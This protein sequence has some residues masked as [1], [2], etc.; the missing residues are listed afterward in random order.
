MLEAVVCDF[1]HTLAD[2]IKFKQSTAMAAAK[3]MVEHGLPAS[4][5]E[6]YSHIFFVYDAH[7]MEYEKTYYEVLVNF[8]MDINKAER[9]QQA[10][11]VAHQKVMADVL[12]C[13]PMVKPTLAE[14]RAMGL[15]LGLVS[16]GPRNKVWKRMVI[17]GL[18][19]EFPVV[20]THSDTEKWK[21]DPAPF[22]LAIEM[23][24]VKAGNILFVGDDKSRD[25]LGAR[26][27]GM[28]TCHA[29]Y[30][31]VGMKGYSWYDK[32]KEVDADFT[33]NRFEELITVVE[34][35]GVSPEI[36][37]MA[38]EGRASKL[39]RRGK[40]AVASAKTRALEMPVLRRF[41]K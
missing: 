37:R 30:G 8:G 39:W 34:N 38:R 4:E 11:I 12:K 32:S 18:A 20:V 15:K 33:I 22:L 35:V 19:A 17:T 3:A 27:V 31:S 24:G 26:E 14:L 28:V 7:G 1:D 21:P 10:A 9:I 36:T 29:K 13:Y 6:A 40:M 25:I 2:F 41:N 16:D 23:L 5:R